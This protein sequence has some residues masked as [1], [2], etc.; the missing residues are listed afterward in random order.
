MLIIFSFLKEKYLGSDLSGN[1][2]TDVERLQCSA[3]D[4]HIL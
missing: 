4:I 2:A 3:H 1:S